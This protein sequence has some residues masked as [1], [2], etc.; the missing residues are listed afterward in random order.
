MSIARIGKG[1]RQS[2]NSISTCS[3]VAETAVMTPRAALP[4]LVFTANGGL[5]LGRDVIL[6]DFLHREPTAARWSQSASSPMS[7][8]S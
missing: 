8:F 5:V 7:V 6:G 3:K 1:S 4:D 2:G